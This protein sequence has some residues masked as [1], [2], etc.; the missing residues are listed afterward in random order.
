MLLFSCGNA[1]MKDKV[2]DAEMFLK[3]VLY[4]CPQNTFSGRCFEDGI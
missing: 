2:E 1:N 3:I 4:T